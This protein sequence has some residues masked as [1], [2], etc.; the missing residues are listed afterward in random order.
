MLYCFQNFFDFNE[1]NEIKKLFKINNNK[2][3]IKLVSCK[4][5]PKNFS[6]RI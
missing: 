4:S 3:P 5:S 6:T 2:K 1:I